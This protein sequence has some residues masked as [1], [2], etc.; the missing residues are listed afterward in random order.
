MTE[1]SAPEN[2]APLWNGW[3]IGMFA[4]LLALG[5][6][7]FGWTKTI[8]LDNRWADL[9]SVFQATCGDQETLNAVINELVA[10][11]D[12]N[13]ELRAQFSQL[14]P[15]TYPAAEIE[16]AGIGQ[17]G[18]DPTSEGHIFPGLIA[19]PEYSCETLPEAHAPSIAD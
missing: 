9:S 12:G 13:L 10:G 18:Y 4:G 6:M 7:F 2:S 3:A 11:E 5:A 17:T 14:E 19:L 16:V 8:Q 1:S 15:R